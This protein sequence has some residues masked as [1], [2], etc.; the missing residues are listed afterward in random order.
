MRATIKLILNVLALVLMAPLGIPCALEKLLLP[1]CE[2]LYIIGAQLVSLLP[3]LPGSYLRKAFYWY[4][5]DAC[6]LECFIGFG[7]FFTHRSA[8]IER[9]VYIGRCA[10]LGSVNLREGCLIGSKSSIL[11]GGKLHED[12]GQGGW[13]PFDASKM[14]RVEIGRKAWIGEGAILM[15][16]VAEGSMVSAGAVVSAAVPAHVMVA[17][18]PARFVR[19]LSVAATKLENA[20]AGA[21]EAAQA[22]AE[23]A[24]AA[25]QTPASAPSGGSS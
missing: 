9:G 15:A 3:G 21:A 24:S 20:P 16:S 14:Q 2:T 5:L 13:T 8:L 4:T 18:N 23:V 25:A 22:K 19:K 1:Q 6:S 12:D 10:L 11:S 17:G 7:T